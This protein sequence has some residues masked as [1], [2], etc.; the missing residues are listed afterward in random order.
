MARG[1]VVM[2]W[3]APLFVLLL[4]RC[5]SAWKDPH[6]LHGRS[7]M[8]HLFEWKFQDVA[9]ECERFLAPH[10]FGGVQVSPVHESLVVESPPRPWWERY[11][12]M[13]YAIEGRS[14]DEQQFADMVRRCN[15]VGVRVYVDVVLNHMTGDAPDPVRGTAGSAAD[16]KRSWYPGVPFNQSNFH[17]NC[18]LHDYNNDVEV[19]NCR[20]VGLHDL[21]MRQ[22][23]VRSKQVVF[24]NTLISHGVAGFR[25]DAAKH[26]WPEDMAAIFGRLHH[27]EESHGFPHNAKPFIF[28]EVIDMGGEGISWTQYSHLGRVTDFKFG[29][30]IGR[31]FRGSNLLKWLKTFG[32]SWGLV[33]S[34]DSVVFVDNHDNQRGHGGGGSNILTH[35]DPR[36]YKMAVAFMLGWPHAEV[37]RIMSS[38]SFVQMDDGPP[39]ANSRT[40]DIASVEVRDDLSCAGG[41]VCEHRWRQIYN[42]VAFRNVVHGTGVD[43]WWD[44]GSNQIAFCRGRM[45]FMAFN[46]QYGVHLKKRL[47]TCL[48]PGVYCDVIS[49]EKKNGRC[50]GKSV[51]VEDREGWAE[52]SIAAD[53]MDGV[54]ALHEMARL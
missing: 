49:G 15:T 43:E 28:Q 42:M 16:P 2:R 51:I 50:S 38:F 9:L 14:G 32:A 48:P 19:R 18:P 36:L 54:L 8:V 23:Y 44:N 45:G 30:E 4:S 52:V 35:K 29:D 1:V 34:E 33:P 12:V 20:L 22:E 5:S 13:S 39:M 41:W 37:A 25:V 11:Q 47:K 7:V 6:M 46:G 21:D 53:E 31:A 26:M 17:S 40:G 3:L 24:L 27:L 10:G